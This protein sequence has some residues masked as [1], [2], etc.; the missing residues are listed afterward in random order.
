MKGA[1]KDWRI[2]L[3]G[4]IKSKRCITFVGTGGCV[5]L[6]MFDG[7]L[8]KSTNKICQITAFGC[9]LLKIYPNALS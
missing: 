6:T 5:K 2:V 9:Q 1:M 4:V 7:K 8:A 3:P